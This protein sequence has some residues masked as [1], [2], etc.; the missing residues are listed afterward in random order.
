MVD[1]VALDHESR[2]RV[3]KIG[4]PNESTLGVMG[5][6][7]RVHKDKG[8]DGGKART[9]LTERAMHPGYLEAA[10]RHHIRHYTRVT[11]GQAG[12]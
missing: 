8:F 12:P 4:P 7:S 6:Y 5:S 1:A 2:L 3:V 9:Q 11:N 10:H